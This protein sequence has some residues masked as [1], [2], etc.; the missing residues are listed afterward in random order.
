[1]R[2]LRCIV[3]NAVEIRISILNMIENNDCNDLKIKNSMFRI[4]PTQL[5]FTVINLLLEMLY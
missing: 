3:D 5:E 1:M 4:L 2:E